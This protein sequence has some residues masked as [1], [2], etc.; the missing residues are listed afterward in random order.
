MSVNYNDSMSEVKNLIELFKWIAEHDCE[1]P[2][3][4]LYERDL[5]RFKDFFCADVDKTIQ[6]LNQL[7]LT[8]DASIIVSYAPYIVEGL[9]DENDK[10]KFIQALNDLKEKYKNTHNDQR[11]QEFFD[12]TIENCNYVLN[13]K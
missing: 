1:I 4:E 9:K 11:L 10:L 8:G 7:D 3:D 6:I 2:G 5:K 12:R 13:D